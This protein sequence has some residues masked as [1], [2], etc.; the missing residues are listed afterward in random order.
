[1]I[2]TVKFNFTKNKLKI[3]LEKRDRNRAI[4]IRQD[5]QGINDKK[6]NQLMFVIPVSFRKDSRIKLIVRN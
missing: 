6:F 5:K 3:F 1:M 4:K 2:M